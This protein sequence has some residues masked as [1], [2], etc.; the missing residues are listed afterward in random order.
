MPFRE[1]FLATVRR[2]AVEYFASLVRRAKAR[3]EL[4]PGVPEA[5]VLFLLD[6]LFDRFLQAVAVPGPGCHPG[7]QPGAGGRDP[8]AD[9]GTGATPPGWPG[10]V[11]LELHPFR[12]GYGWPT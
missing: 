2:H 1:E 9:P 12:G 7:S 6:A 11:V 8:Q 4:R 5:A 10:G 3:G